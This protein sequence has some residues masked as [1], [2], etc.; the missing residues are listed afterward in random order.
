MCTTVRPLKTQEISTWD[1]ETVIVKK[2]AKITAV[3]DAIGEILSLMKEGN[4]SRDASKKLSVSTQT[5][6]SNGV[7]TTNREIKRFLDD[8]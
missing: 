2:V 7:W 5:E 4:L 8:K 6:K 1:R 3:N